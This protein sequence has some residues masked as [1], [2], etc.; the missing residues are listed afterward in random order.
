MWPSTGL[1]SKGHCGSLSH[2]RS[3]NKHIITVVF[4]T[5]RS[6][7]LHIASAC[8]P[9][10]CHGELLCHI[11][12]QNKRI[13][14]RV[15]AIVQ[16]RT[17]ITH[18][19]GPLPSIRKSNGMLCLCGSFWNYLDLPKITKNYLNVRQI[20]SHFLKNPQKSSKF[21]KNPQKSSNILPRFT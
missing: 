21:L 11:R 15:F 6:Q 19:H 14:P 9:R 1:P 4:A 10:R 5:A 2:L 7:S 13:N 8:P 17:Y 3:V 12:A 16:S 20:Y 18:G